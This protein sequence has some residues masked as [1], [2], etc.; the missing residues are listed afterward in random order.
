LPK[1]AQNCQICQ[2]LPKDNLL[3]ELWNT[4]KNWDFKF[5]QKKILYVEDAP[6]H[7]FTVWIF[8]TTIFC[9]PPLLSKN[10]LCM[11]I[12]TFPLVEFLFF[13]QCSTPLVGMRFYRHIPNSPRDKNKYV[14]QSMPTWKVVFWAF[15][16]LLS[17]F[18]IGKK[19]FFVNFKCYDL[20]NS[21]EWVCKI[22]W[23][24]RHRS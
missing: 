15:K 23:T 8:N 21:K 1:T 12:S 20:S 4:T 16:T 13:S 6:K 5:F 10:D 9:M 19:N 7:Y 22:W 2:N 18:G 14:A 24:C 3:E 17:P 11:W